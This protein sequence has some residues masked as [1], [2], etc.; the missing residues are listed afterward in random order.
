MTK[1]QEIVEKVFQLPEDKKQEILDFSEFILNKIQNA[2]TVKPV[3]GSAKGKYTLS[4]DFDEPLNF[5]KKTCRI[6]KN[7]IQNTM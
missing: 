2:K 7:E 1:E 5:I 4:N 3:F 6:T